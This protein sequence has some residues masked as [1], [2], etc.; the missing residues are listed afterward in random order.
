M[1]KRISLYLMIFTIVIV[2][3]CSK[4]GD[5]NIFTV[6]QDIAFGKQVDSLVRADYNVVPRDANNT[7]AYAYLDNMMQSILS[8]EEL[9][10]RDKF[11]WQITIIEEDK[12]NA[13]AA[14]GGKLFFYTGLMKYLDNSAEL[15]GVMAHE[16]AHAD[17]RHSTENMTKAYGFSFLLS[18]IL[19]NDPSKVEE[20]V[21]GLAQGLGE[22]AFSRKHEY[23]A[24]EFAV[25][26]T[27]D[28]KYTPTGVAGFFEKLQ[29]EDDGGSGTPTFL[30]T[31]P[32]PGNRV[33]AIYE[34]WDGLG[35]PG[36]QNFEEEYA[37][38]KATLP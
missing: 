11:P 9:L 28:T 13:F 8:S 7:E 35:S 23:E 17:R 33:D 34:V 37:N 21:A 32:D 30:S 29:A 3:N 36:G 27:S 14:P 6:N 5:V 15:A 19:G 24:D 12:L 10:Y 2:S 22:L 4:D 25:R 16:I 31:H 38:F 26:Y 20:I 1:K 18:V